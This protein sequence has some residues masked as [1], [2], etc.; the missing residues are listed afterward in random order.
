MVIGFR[1]PVEGLA[2][3]RLFTDA[4]IEKGRIINGAARR[5]VLASLNDSIL[6]AKILLSKSEMNLTVEL[7]NAVAC[8]LLTQGGIKTTKRHKPS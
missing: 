3:L 1:E 2:L 6:P 5:A 7:G 8:N 4:N